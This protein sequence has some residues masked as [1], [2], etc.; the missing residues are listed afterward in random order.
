MPHKILKPSFVRTDERGVFTEVLNEGHWETLIAGEMNPGGVMG[1][2]YHRETTVF[3]YIVR[4][5]AEVKTLHVS[6]AARDGFQLASGE[7]V[8]LH[9]H[10]SHAIHFLERTEYIMLKSKRYDSANP[11]TFELRVE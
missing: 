1:N 8:M 9:S 5:S 10:E 4:G 2:H 3:F 7:G 6:T 11:D